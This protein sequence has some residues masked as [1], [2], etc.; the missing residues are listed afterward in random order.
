MVTNELEAE[1]FHSCCLYCSV[2]AQ[3]TLGRP[4]IVGAGVIQDGF[5]LTAFVKTLILQ[6]FSLK[7][8]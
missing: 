4:R 2:T 8:R 6:E 3:P 1:I 7:A 5:S